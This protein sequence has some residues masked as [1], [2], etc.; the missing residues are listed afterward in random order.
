MIRYAL[1]CSDDHSF[2]SWFASAKAFDTVKSAGMVVCPVC[3]SDQVEKAIMA[4]RVSPARSKA[5][6]PADRPLAAPMSDAEKALSEVRKHVEEN[7]DY[8]GLGFAAEAR[9]MHQGEAPTRSIYGEARTE[10]A[11]KLIE[12]GVPVAP[13]PFIPQRKTN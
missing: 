6:K 12:E 1:K 2:E 9:K 3:G 8:V 13:L 11:K 10:D 7:S 4:P 5:E